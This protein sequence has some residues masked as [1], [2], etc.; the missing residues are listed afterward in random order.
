MRRTRLGVLTG[1]AVFAIA[2][3]GSGDKGAVPAAGAPA[4]GATSAALTG[5]GATFPNPIYQKWFDS[6]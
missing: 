3:G 2:C 6:A 1:L 5:A 4:A